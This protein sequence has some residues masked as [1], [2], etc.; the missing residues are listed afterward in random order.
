MRFNQR[1]QEEGESVD[2]FVTSLHCLAKDCGYKGL[3]SEMIRYQIVVGPRNANLSMKLQM[4]ANLNLEKAVTI[5]RQSEAVQLQQGV[6]RGRA[7]IVDNV[8]AYKTGK[9]VPQTSNFLMCKLLLPSHHK[10]CSRCG[11]FPTHSRKSALQ[12]IKIVI[13]VAR[14]AII[15]PCAEHEKLRMWKWIL[16]DDKSTHLKVKPDVILGTLTTHS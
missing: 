14:K 10:T 9:K 1:Q 8:D 3:K 16:H 12:I 15:I 2:L 11:G 5:A 4:I 7:T 6:V 13:S